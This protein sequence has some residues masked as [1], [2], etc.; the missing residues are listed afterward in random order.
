MKRLIIF[1]LNLQIRR[2][3]R[4]MN[5]ACAAKDM[6]AGRAHCDRFMALVQIRNLLIKQ[7]N[8]VA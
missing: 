3:Q 5:R 2:A 1:L 6:L 7:F 8:E 4:A